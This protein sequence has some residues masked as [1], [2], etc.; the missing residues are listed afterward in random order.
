[1]IL[2]RILS[3][4]HVAATDNI[5]NVH[6]MPESA[7]NGLIFLV[8][9]TGEFSVRFETSYNG[10]DWYAINELDAFSVS[11]M[12]SLSSNINLFSFV[13]AKIDIGDNG[14]SV[15]TLLIFY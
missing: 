10:Q 7:D 5:S 9:G 8:D 15:D 12:Q 11:S 2:E 1:M 14:G 6:K 13:R 3:L 4:K